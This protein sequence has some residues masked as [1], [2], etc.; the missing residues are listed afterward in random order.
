MQ[1]LFFQSSELSPRAAV[2]WQKLAVVHV[3][4][5]GKALGKDCTVCYMSTGKK[6]RACAHCEL[7][8][9][10]S[11]SVRCVQC[12]LRLCTRCRQENYDLSSARD[13]C[14][15][16]AYPVCWPG[17]AMF[18][19]SARDPACHLMAYAVPNENSLAAIE[20]TG[21]PVVEVGAGTGYWAMLLRDRGVKVVAYDV[22]PAPARGSQA[23]QLA[24]SSAGGA[25][26]KR[27]QNDYHAEIPAFTE[28][29]QGGTEASGRHPDHALFLC[30]P[31]PKSTMAEECL[32]NYKGSTL[33]YVGE[34][35]GD[36]G[37]WATAPMAAGWLV[38]LIF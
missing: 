33:L 10:S 34:W 1:A 5:S 36:T 20:A 14:P 21:L 29:L 37:R 15:R 24:L 27:A 19:D 30:Y 9:C 35:E 26:R 22:A 28:V 6:R 32:Q 11:C 31:P 38:E 8:V 17:L 18:R 13:F 3:M 25:Q 12:N 16:C 4:D 23:E 7:A 2:Q